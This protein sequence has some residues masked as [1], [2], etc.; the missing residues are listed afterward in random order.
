M[1]KLIPLVITSKSL[2][3]VVMVVYSWASLNTSVPKDSSTKNAWLTTTKP[4]TRNA[5][6]LL[7]WLSARA[8]RSST[9]VSSKR[10]RTSRERLW[11]TDLWSLLLRSTWISWLISLEFTR[12]LM[13]LRNLEDSNNGKSSDGILMSKTTPTGSLKIPGELHGEKTALS[14][15]EPV[16]TRTS[17]ARWPSHQDPE[18]RLPRRKRLK[19][20]TLMVIFLIFWLSLFRIPSWRWRWGRWW[21]VGWRWRGLVMICFL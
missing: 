9:S 8:I 18:W 13:E 11:I 16:K 10:K 20:M 17:S 3:P 6:Q 12:I 21:W 7:N 15:S 1:G 5:H 2:R 19:R 4:G 14:E